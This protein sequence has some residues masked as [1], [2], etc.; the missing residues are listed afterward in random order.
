MPEGDSLRNI[1][2]A[3]TPLVENQRMIRLRT[4]DVEHDALV[5]ETLGAPRARGKHLLVPIGQHAILHV[6]HGL[7]GAWHAYLPGDRWRRPPAAAAVVLETN[8]HV[9]PCF[10]P[11]LVELLAADQV[12]QHGMIARLGPDL[13][14]P[15]PDF[16]DVMARVRRSPALSIAALLLDQRVAAGIGNIYKN[17]ILFL[18]E[19]HPWTRPQDL[20]DASIR[21]MYRLASEQM[22]DNVRPGLRTTTPRE[23]QKKSRDR[24]WVYSRVGRPC[25]RCGT[26]IR[27]RQQG[28]EGR[29]TFWC[30]SCQPLPARTAP[31]WRKIHQR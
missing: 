26:T 16:D 22:K 11:M 23:V 19:T 28:D 13:L 12:N 24:F 5:G 1:V 29:D 21:A 20:D 17:E 10:D 14:D 4:A 8:G 2:R 25:I 27:K 6:H 3:L 31:D 15:A 30:S 18:T 7:N 9:L